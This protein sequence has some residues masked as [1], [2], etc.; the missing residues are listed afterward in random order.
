MPRI[1]SV[2]LKD[3][4][5]ARLFE[6]RS[7]KGSVSP[8]EALD[9]KRPLVLAAPG[10]GGARIAALNEAAR[11][12]GLAAG[13]LLSNVRSKVLDLQAC[14]ADPAADANALGRL[15]RMAGSAAQRS[16]KLSPHA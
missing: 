2:W 15:A 5:I 4:S 8:A 1:V 10:K 14:D 6:T 11:R 12:S 13:E 3:W 16:L 7:K 9:P